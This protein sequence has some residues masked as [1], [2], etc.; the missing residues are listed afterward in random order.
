MAY[1]MTMALRHGMAMGDCCTLFCFS[2]SRSQPYLPLV[3]FGEI[4]PN[5]EGVVWCCLVG[6]VD[7]ESVIGTHLL[8]FGE[9]ADGL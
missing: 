5:G 7:G 1:S 3:N 8:L 6:G 9:R 2:P 4:S